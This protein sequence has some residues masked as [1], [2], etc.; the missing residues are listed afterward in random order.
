MSVIQVSENESIV[1]AGIA[2]SVSELKDNSPNPNGVYVCLDV[3]W[4]VISVVAVVLIERYCN[5]LIQTI[6]RLKAIL[7]GL[8]TSMNVGLRLYLY[9]TENNNFN[10]LVFMKYAFDLG[11][12]P[13]GSVAQNDIP[14]SNWRYFTVVGLKN[15]FAMVDQALTLHLLYELYLCTNVMQMREHDMKRFYLQAPGVFF[16]SLLGVAAQN[17]LLCRYFDVFN[18][19][20]MI[21]ILIKPF[22][23]LMMIL[24]SCLSIFLGIKTLISLERS[25]E[26][27][28]AC[29]S[30][31]MAGR[32]TLLYTLLISQFVFQFLKLA[33]HV[34]LM[35]WMGCGKSV[36]E[37]CLQSRT[38]RIL[39]ECL[40]TEAEET[41]TIAIIFS[42][43]WYNIAEYIPP[44][45][46]VLASKL[47]S[48]GVAG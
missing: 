23:S 12:A 9:F 29:S 47:R 17:L 7:F 48:C 38:P 19:A 1:I 3:L 14:W 45:L 41:K 18:W 40:E 39:Q 10:V 8:I 22:E 26:I 5:S 24:L 46:P 27:R 11:R 6:F 21:T 13:S 44:L 4:L 32:N 31:A 35:V 34:G 28:K 43:A 25:F 16:G 37:I 2:P 20:L 42:S 33:V 15:S 36:H 30:A